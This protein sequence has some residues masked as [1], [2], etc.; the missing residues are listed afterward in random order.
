MS[1]A[2]AARKAAGPVPG[3]GMHRGALGPSSAFWCEGSGSLGAPSL[4]DGWIVLWPR[5]TS[6]TRAQGWAGEGWGDRAPCSPVTRPGAAPDM[7]CHH[8]TSRPC[9]QGTAPDRVP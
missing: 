3:P 9:V 2:R 8:A 4:S 7:A 6:R 1:R 5:V